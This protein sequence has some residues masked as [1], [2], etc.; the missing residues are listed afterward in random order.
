MKNFRIISDSS[1]DLFSGHPNANFK[2]EFATVPLK[3]IINQVEYP[4]NNSTDV[5]KMFEHMK[6]FKGASSTA[7]PSI[8]DFANEFLLA[9][10]SIAL[11]ISSGLSGTFNTAMQARQLVLD[12]HPNKQIHIIDTHSTAGNM[13]LLVRFIDQLI[14]SGAE[15]DEVVEKA[16]AYSQ[17]GK[18]IFSLSSFDNLV[19]GGRMSKSASVVASALKIRAIA[20]NSTV[21]TIQVINKIRG[22]KKAFEEIA[23]LLSEVRDVTKNPIVITHCCNEQG[24]T[25][26]AEILKNKY[27]AKDITILKTRCLT[28]FYADNGGVLACI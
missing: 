28:S 23:K 22:D 19:K 1:C 25:Q 24:A 14:A 18:I 27:K 21:G 4:D 8:E 10:Y 7:C 11:T 16:E 6:S 15:F 2:T 17:N 3:I 9:D 5:D 12:E 13:V 20:T 26:V